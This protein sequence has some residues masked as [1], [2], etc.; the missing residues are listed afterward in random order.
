M[1][2]ENYKKTLKL[3]WT[4]IPIF[5]VIILIIDVINGLYFSNI[6]E[7]FEHENNEV[8]FY[9]WGPFLGLI[10]TMPLWVHLFNGKVFRWVF[11]AI[12][13][14]WL[15]MFVIASTVEY[16]GDIIPIYIY[17]TIMIHNVVTAIATYNSFKW[18]KSYGK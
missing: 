1:N 17:E 3:C 12:T 13:S 16:M 11:F 6:T 2:G 9:K 5:F 14:I 10:T 7:W 18:A 15:I 8:L 4:L